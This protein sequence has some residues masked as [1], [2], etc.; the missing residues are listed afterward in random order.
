ML[1][2]AHLYLVKG[3]L[4]TALSLVGSSFPQGHSYK[5]GLNEFSDMTMDEQLRLRVRVR[6]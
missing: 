3:Q 1:G 6:V 5:L 4:V 2:N